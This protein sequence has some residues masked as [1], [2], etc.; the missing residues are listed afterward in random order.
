MCIVC[1]V[2]VV[3][4]CFSLSLTHTVLSFT[5]KHTALFLC[6]VLISKTVSVYTT[7]G[8][9][10]ERQTR[11]K[12]ERKRGRHYRRCMTVSNCSQKVGGAAVEYIQRT[13]D[14]K[15]RV[16]IHERCKESEPGRL[17]KRTL[18]LKTGNEK[19]ERRDR[20]GSLSRE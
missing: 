1:R 10:E 18:K 11:M 15:R 13:L 8:S 3:R 20:E 14:K 16:V 6:V 5:G 9:V 12:Q 2:R 4:V 19:G 7:T 17:K